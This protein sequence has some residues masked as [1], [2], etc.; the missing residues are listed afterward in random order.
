ME[1][2]YD[3]LGRGAKDVVA[4]QAVAVVAPQASTPEGVAETQAVALDRSTRR[5]S[6]RAGMPTTDVRL[7]D[8]RH[9]RIREPGSFGDQNPGRDWQ[10]RWLVGGHWRQQAC[11]PNRSERR[12]VW[13][14][15]HVK[16]PEDK[17]LK[18]KPTVHVV[19]P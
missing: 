9:R 4:P 17:P 14:A 12:P 7:V 10:S 1:A 5:R 15:P 8:V 13:I 19:R 16:G 2:C 18:V 6:Q 3:I 11:G